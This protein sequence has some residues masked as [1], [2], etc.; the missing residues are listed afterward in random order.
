MAAGVVPLGAQPNVDVALYRDTGTWAPE[1][2]NALPALLT[3]LNLPFH[4]ITADDIKAGKLLKDGKPTYH[5]LIVPGGWA[6]SYIVK[7]GGWG[8]RG[9]ADIKA[10]LQ[11]GG[12]YLG[13]CAGA[14]AACSTVKWEGKDYNS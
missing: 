8:N 3:W 7:L 6:P 1:V 2:D 5:L 4:P 11:A 13:F 14:F 9:G 12:H 10:F